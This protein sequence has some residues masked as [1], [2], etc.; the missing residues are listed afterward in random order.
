MWTDERSHATYKGLRTGHILAG[1]FNHP[2]WLQHYETW[3]GTYGIWELTDPTKK[4]Y[5]SGNALDKFLFLQGDTIPAMFLRESTAEEEEVST[6]SAFYP[7]E[8]GPEERVGNHHPVFLSL[9]HEN[10]GA[11]PQ[12]RKLRI[13]SS[14]LLTRFYW[15]KIH[16]YFN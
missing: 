6:Q 10:S 7:A 15:K 2:S 8:T 11:P 4:T 12:C 9:P 13:K 16:K 1:D 5:S 3:I 14:L